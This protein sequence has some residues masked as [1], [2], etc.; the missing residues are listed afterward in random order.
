MSPGDLLPASLLAKLSRL[1]LAARRRLGG[2]TAGERVSARRG[3]SMEFAE[4][5]GYAAGDDLRYLDWNLLARMDRPFLKTYQEEEDVPVELLVDTS[6]SM[7]FGTPSKLEVA[8]RLAAALAWVALSAL[9]RVR[10]R[11]VRAD[12]ATPAASAPVR[13]RAGALRIAEFLS[14]LEPAGGTALASGLARLARGGRPGITVVISDFL[15]PDGAEA[16]LSALAARGDQVHAVHVLAD[17]ELAPALRGDLELVD[18]ETGA[19][20]EVSL[21]PRMLARY[22]ELVDAFRADLAAACRK[23]GAGY[24]AVRTGE[25]VEDVVLRL[26]RRAGMVS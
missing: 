1:R 21:S 18:S 6:M 19:R 20:R 4:H 5:R 22:G 11:A 26:M 24:V 17:E 7:A 8:A 10:V 14:R 12:A 9:D 16:G 13:G 23:R 3:H 25:P 2:R 15:D